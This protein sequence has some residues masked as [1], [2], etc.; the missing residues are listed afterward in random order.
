MWEWDNSQLPTLIV[1]AIIL[2]DFDLLRT[3]VIMEILFE[4]YSLTFYNYAEFHV[5]S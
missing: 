5:I 1:I 2:C 3:N 4:T